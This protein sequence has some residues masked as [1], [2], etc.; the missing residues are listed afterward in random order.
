M[1]R[2]F[3]LVLIDTVLRNNAISRATGRVEEGVGAPKDS[4]GNVKQPVEGGRGDSRSLEKCDL[5]D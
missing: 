4:F 2:R 3:W 5:R 1:G